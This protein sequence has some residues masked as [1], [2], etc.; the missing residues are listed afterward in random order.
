[1]NPTGSP[2]LLG[3]AL[4]IAALSLVPL[5]VVTTTSFLKI[6]LVLVVL[7]NAIGVQQV[8]PTLAIYG[9]ALA[10][11]AF[12][13]A[14]TLQAVATELVA[15]SSADSTPGAGQPRTA[16]T[17][18]KQMQTVAEPIR[19]FM[20]RYAGPSQR[21]AMLDNARRL[22]PPDMAKAA[23]SSD[24]LILLPAFVISELQAGFEIGFLIYIPFVVIDL[25][26]SNLLMAIGMQSVQAT[27]LTVPLKMLLFIMVDGWSRLLHALAL[28]YQVV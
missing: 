26:V 10:M 5:T 21:E 2:D 14:P 18:L 3:M 9:I 12:V 22:W 11:T 6:A 8:P 1:M 16:G 28:S 7:R 23:T 15:F 13:M 27:V 4:A 17:M 25:L 19:A 20:L 24:F